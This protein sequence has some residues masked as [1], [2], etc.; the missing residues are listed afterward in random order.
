MPL[1]AL[2]LVRVAWS[3]PRFPPRLVTSPPG[4]PVLATSA[5]ACIAGLGDCNAN[6]LLDG[7]ETSLTTTTNCGACA[8]ACS[9]SNVTGS[10]CTAGACSGTC[11]AGYGN[12]NG[13]LQTD[14]C[15][16]PL[17][18]ATNCGACGVTC[19]SPK[20]CTTGTCIWRAPKLS[21]STLRRD[22]RGFGDTP[23][24]SGESVCGAGCCAACPNFARRRIVVRCTDAWTRDPPASCLRSQRSHQLAE[25][26]LSFNVLV[27]PGPRQENP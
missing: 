27:P 10:A 20:L 9:A 5:C 4:D 18:T 22:R 14:G 16:T 11:A 19:V 24:A 21:R 3:E 2:L 6:M 26:S 23:K 12:C 17:N 7:C 8:R 25:H 1:A 13:T 15:E